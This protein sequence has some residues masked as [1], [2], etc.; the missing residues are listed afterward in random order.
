MVKTEIPKKEGRIESP[1]F[2]K[3]IVIYEDE[4]RELYKDVNILKRETSIKNKKTRIEVTLTHSQM[5]TPIE[6][7]NIKELH[8]S[9]T[10]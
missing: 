4:S 1:K 10:A 3:V 2:R 8:C 6:L 7:F 9:N 5:V